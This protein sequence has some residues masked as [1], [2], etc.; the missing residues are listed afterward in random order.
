M[1][2]LKF[3]LF[4]GTNETGP[5]FVSLATFKKIRPGEA[6]CIWKV[7]NFSSILSNNN[8]FCQEIIVRNIIN[9]AASIHVTVTSLQIFF[10][11]VFPI[12]WNSDCYLCCCNHLLHIFFTVVCP[13][14]WGTHVIHIVVTTY[15]IFS[16]LWSAP[17][18]GTAPVIH[19]VVTVITDIFYCH[20]SNT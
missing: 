12:R 3:S 15:Y 9:W 7:N 19:T 10:T 6:K 1:A 11:A 18:I 20:L 8:V 16:L 13:I 14:P 4:F 5:V 2:T 17:Y